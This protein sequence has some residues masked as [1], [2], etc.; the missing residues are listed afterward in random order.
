MRKMEEAKTEAH[1]KLG[2]NVASNL[3]SLRV[4]THRLLVLCVIP[5]S[6]TRC[7]DTSGSDSSNNKS[8]ALFFDPKNGIFSCRIRVFD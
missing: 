8:F 7:S 6:T 5:Y 1:D 3:S 4:M 2:P